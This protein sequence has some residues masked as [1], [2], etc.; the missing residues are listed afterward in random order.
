MRLGRRQKV[1]QS[2]VGGHPGEQAEHKAHQDV[3]GHKVGVERR[4]ECCHAVTI[5]DVPFRMAGDKMF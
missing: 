2:E 5:T 4:H 3:G 1:R